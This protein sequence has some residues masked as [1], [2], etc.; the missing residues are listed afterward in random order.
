MS[1]S[2][3]NSPK[4]DYFLVLNASLTRGFRT[5][6]MKPAILGY[7]QIIVGSVGLILV[8]FS[9][10]KF[11][12]P[13]NDA[14]QQMDMLVSRVGSEIEDTI[15]LIQ[16]GASVSEEIQKSIPT[17]LQSI[18]QSKVAINESV[19]IVEDWQ[20]QIPRIRS[21]MLDGEKICNTYADQLPIKLPHV[22]SKKVSFKYPEIIPRTTDIDLPYPTAKVKM[23]GFSEKI[24]NQRIGFQYPS[25]IDIDNLNKRITVPTNPTINEKEIAFEI[26]DKIYMMEY[27]KKEKEMIQKTAKQLKDIE[28]S[29]GKSS[30][31]IDIIKSKV[32]TELINSIDKTIIGVQKSEDLLVELNDKTIPQTVENLKAQQTSIRKTSILFSDFAMGIPILFSMLGLV[33][34]AILSSGLFKVI[35]M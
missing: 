8:A 34:I 2:D 25:G 24:L 28:A 10:L 3:S 19:K 22:D 17:H 15:A 4:K 5:L 1:S 6:Q 31:S 16:K 30:E 32:K 12:G 7:A 33:F 26:P 18:E 35:M 27:M 20:K 9:F 11:N 14:L 29:V 21:I 23:S 13:L